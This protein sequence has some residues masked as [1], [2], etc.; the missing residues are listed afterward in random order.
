MVIDAVDEARDP[1]GLLTGLLLPLA[2]CPGLRVVV[3]ARRHI[4]PPAADTSLMIDLDTDGYRDP[5]ALADYARQ[6]LVATHEPDELTPYRHQGGEIAA[7]VAAAIAEKATARPTAAGRAESFLLAQ[8]LARAVRGRPQVLD[9]TRAGWADQLP[10]DVGAAFDEDL[11]RLGKREPTARALLTALAWA[12]G[13]GLPWERI[14]V[15]VAQ[16]IATH[17]AT[18]ASRLGDNHVRW[19][20]NNAGAYIVEDVGPGQ[21]SVFRPFHDLL[22]AHLRGQPTDEQILTDPAAVDAWQQRREQIERDITRVLLDSIPSF[23]DGEAN[24]ELAHPYLRTYLAQHARAAGPDMFTA[25]AADLDY[26]AVADPAILT[27][28]L[29]PTDPA[30]QRLARP[31]RRARA[32]LGDSARANAAYLQ[33]AVIAQTGNHPAGQRIQPAYRTLMAHVRRDDSLLTLATGI[34]AVKSIA[35]GSGADGR[36]L[37][38][39]GA[40]GAVRLWDPATGDPVGAPL[41]H[42]GL[43]TAVAFGSGADGRPLLASAEYGGVRLWDPATGDPVGAPL[44]HTHVG[45]IAFGSGADGR[46]LL[47]SAEYGGVRLWDPATGDPVG[48]P[49]PHNDLVRAMAFGSGADGRPLLACGEYEAVRLWDP[50]TGDP[51]GPPLPM[52]L[53]R[54][55]AFGSGA[56]GRP[57]LASDDTDGTDGTVRL[58]DPATGDPV[59][60]P[61]SD[62]THPYGPRGGA[63]VAFGADADGRLL[64]ACGD[65]AGT[66]RLWDPATGDP[67]GALLSGHTGAVRAVALGAGADGRP[68]LASGGEDGTVRLWDPA[69]DPSGTPPVERLSSEAWSVAFGAGADGRPL[70]ASGGDDVTVRLWDPATGDPVGAPLSGH[71]GKVRAMAFGSGADGRPLLACGE[72][73]GVRLWDPA[74]GDRVAGTLVAGVRLPHL[75]HTG[76]VTAVAFG[77]DADGRP[78]LASCGEDGVRVW[79]LATMAKI[80]SLRGGAVVAFGAGA[81]GRLLLACSEYGGVRL[82][83]PATGD[84]VGAPLAGHTGAVTAVAFG[85]D[86]DGRPLLASGGDDGTVRLWDPATG[87]PVGAPLAGHTGRVREVAFG[88]DADGRPLLASGGDDGTNGTVRLWDLATGDPIV[89]LLRR[90]AVLAIATQNTRLAIADREGVTVLEITSGA[91]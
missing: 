37:L 12:N 71:T 2:R 86:A 41:P 17:A 8:L 18:D 7:T 80:A 23:S 14:W 36:P 40:E 65:T 74:T 22:A 61:L 67:V 60:A 21:R 64:L 56:D 47:A 28:M 75:P 38:A 25:L 43:V 91:R 81:D 50:A 46:P 44:P 42:R 89:T 15:P 85:A 11:R 26:L 20:L 52:G 34:G 27:P 70:L 9:I 54:A 82:W 51:V 6:L 68:L 87:D 77:A 66:V 39:C 57:L 55:V 48:A 1:Y 63:V 3:G 53:V 73:E 16:I 24:W 88:A 4:L 83:D 10:A 32:L 90:T 31:Y 76:S 49:L 59:G 19:L 33:E 30:L 72:Y 5:Q 84:P 58:W 45:S 69:T 35:F 13:P 78:L 79:D 62:H 29:T